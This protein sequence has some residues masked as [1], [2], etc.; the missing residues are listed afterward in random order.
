MIIYNLQV[1]KWICFLCIVAVAALFNAKTVFAADLVSGHYI[2]SSGKTIEL[3]IDIQSPSPASLIIEQYLPP[4]TKIAS[5]QPK[6]KKY[7]IKKG[8]AKWLLKNVRSGKMIV[9]L[10]LADTLGKGRIQALLRCKDPA[11]GGF[12]EMTVTP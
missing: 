5:S 12:V 4:G 7:D 2:S 11:T 10:Q 6:L 1:K 3:A 8:K 9:K